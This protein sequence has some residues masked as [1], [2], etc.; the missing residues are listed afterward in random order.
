MPCSRCGSRYGLRSVSAVISCLSRSALPRSLRL[1]LRPRR[2][3]LLG[4]IQVAEDG[5]RKTLVLEFPLFEGAHFHLAEQDVNLVLAFFQRL[6]RDPGEAQPIHRAQRL[7]PLPYPRDRDQRSAGRRVIGQ[8]AQEFRGHERHVDR[9]N[10]IA[11]RL[12]SPQRRVNAAQR[13]AARKAIVNHLAVIAQPTG[14]AHNPGL[15][16]I[17]RAIASIRAISACP[18]ISSNALSAPIR[19]LCPPAST[20]AL[21]P[22]MQASYT[23]P[24]G[25]TEIYTA[26]GGHCTGS[27]PGPKQLDTKVTYPTVPRR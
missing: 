7:P 19:V 1:L 14:A 23:S 2:L 8:V 10:Q 9:Q 6:L 17:V 3:R 12:R 4:S 16:S 13:A 27:R 21:S 15:R 5:G 20:N 18:S 24:A 11:F 25:G 22:A 26:T